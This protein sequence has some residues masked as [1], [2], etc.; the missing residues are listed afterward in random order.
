MRRLLLISAMCCAVLVA[1][2][3]VL[4][5]LFPPDLSR[6]HDRSTLVVDADGRVLRAFTSRDERWRL[7]ATPQDVDPLFLKMLVA[8][9]DRRFRWHPGVD[10]LAVLRATG[11]FLSHGGIVSGASTLTM[12]TARLLEPHG[13]DLRGKL[14]EMARALQLELRYSKEEILTLYL[15]LAPYGGNLEG[16]RAASLAWLGKEPRSLTPAEAALLV[17][18]PQSPERRRPDLRADIAKRERDWVIDVLVGRGALTAAQRAE[19][20]DR[21]VPAER[22]SMP[23]VAPHL[24]LALANGTESGATIRTHI[25]GA[26]QRGLERLAFESARGFADGADVAMVVVDN[27]TRKVVAY[28]GSADFFGRAGQNDLVRARR[29]PGSALKP[30]AY[31]LAFDDGILH[32]ESLID[33]SPYR[34][35]D[36]APRNF[37]RDF[38]GMLTA[39][40]AL[41]QSLNIPAVAVVNRI[42]PERF[43]AGLQQAGAALAYPRDATGAGSLAIV[44]GGAGISLLDLTMLYAGLAEGGAM[45]PLSLRQGDRPEDEKPRRFV[46]QRAAWYVGD[47]LVGS[48]P[49]DSYAPTSTPGSRRRIAFKTGTSFGFRD[50]WA[51]GYSQRYTVGVWVGHAD[52]TPRP[53][54][55]GRNTAA[56]VMLRAFDLLPPEEAAPPRRPADALAVSG[57]AALPPYLQI[58]DPTAPPLAIGPRARSQASAPRILY[59]VE[60][61]VVELRRHDSDGRQLPLKAEGGQGP[62]RWVVNG[63]PL[64]GQ[65]GSTLWQPDG[66]GF[67]RIAVIDATGRSSAVQVRVQIAD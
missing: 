3:A 12:Q 32:P 27:R 35:G 37:D 53:G 50:A 46:G 65:P 5:R 62:L 64:A 24:A 67:A 6:F 19:A 42:G 63:E 41:Q 36:Y 18:L 34:F 22:R 2:G 38:Q 11:Q 44:L 51:V 26:A 60:G 56:P 66:E 57:T 59:P 52:S 21:P 31:A 58:F 39:R 20:I 30:F 23:F 54:Q 48:A 4:D 7:L 55:F 25:L 17:A 29:S 15:T 61:A 47:I 8:Y 43:A 33:D 16:V 1:A 40:A 49:P 14:F 45:L 13:R 28:V 9:E 10:P